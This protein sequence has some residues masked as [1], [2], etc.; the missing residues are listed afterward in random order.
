MV[1]R[2]RPLGSRVPVLGAAILVALAFSAIAA[3]AVQAHEWRIGGSSMTKLGLTQEATA[4]S[5]T[6]LTIES[7][8]GGTAF[9]F[10]CAESSTG[11]AIRGGTGEATLSLSSCT[12]S[13]PAK[14]TAAPFTLKAKTELVTV[15]GVNYEKFLPKEG[16]T[17]GNVVFSNC[18]QAE[19]YPLKGS[20]AGKAEAGGSLLVEQPVAL[21][22]AAAEAAGTSL[23]MSN[24]AATASAGTLKQGLNGAKKGTTWGPN[25]GAIW[26]S[27]SAGTEWQVEGTNLSKIASQEPIAAKGAS[28]TFSGKLL[29]TPIK[30]TCGAS[31][32]GSL[33]PG[34]LF[35]GM[36]FKFSDCITQEPAGCTVQPFQ[37][38]AMSGSGSTA[39]MTFKPA[40]GPV[41]SVTVSGP[42][43]IAET[44][45]LSGGFTVSGEAN[46]TQLV[47][48][49][50]T[51]SS[52]SLSFGTQA[53]SLTG[54]LNSYLPER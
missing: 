32:S 12:V 44:Y 7:N 50:S 22:K 34:G 10:T 46:G 47:E 27:T 31:A 8:I 29:G 21:S 28:F 33:V 35:E 30:W 3:S 40:S 37:T 54:S 41:A 14:C 39:A 48:Q 20:F 16:Q 13:E 36:S 18:A 5:G 19:T 23:T 2:R 6:G 24:K 25:K 49:P 53:V 26:G 17:F 52:S 11:N 15:G 9:K 38:V 51:V 43:A 4:G 42:C 1:T 45:P